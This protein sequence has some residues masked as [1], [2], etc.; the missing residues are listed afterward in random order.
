MACLNP[1]PSKHITY[2]HSTY[3]CKVYI[4]LHRFIIVNFNTECL[5]MR[6]K[7]SI[8]KGCFLA[9][10]G[11]KWGI[12]AKNRHSGIFFTLLFAENHKFV[13]LSVLQI[14]TFKVRKLSIFGLL[15]NYKISM[16]TTPCIVFQMTIFRL[17]Q[18][19]NHFK[20]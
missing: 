2:Y 19:C 9:V 4:M 11:L 17:T 1:F 18:S 14:F 7:W 15:D 10:N 12:W 5:K 3:S 13:S 6:K 16:L 8:F 20:P